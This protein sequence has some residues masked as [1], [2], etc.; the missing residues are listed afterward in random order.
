MAVQN[1]T[2]NIL[3]VGVQDWDR[4]SFDE[5]MELPDGTS[6]NSFIV[7]GGE[8]TALIDTSDPDKYAEFLPQFFIVS[9]VYLLEDSDI[10][11]I[12][13]DYKSDEISLGVDKAKGKKCAR[14]WIYHEK[15]G[16]DE[17]Y[18]DLCPKCISAIKLQLQDNNG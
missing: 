15:V 16:E 12:D 10:K 1:L 9:N 6:Y 2:K 13:M 8:K 17:E 11:D 7:R 4:R 3:A 14:C 5:F 18:K